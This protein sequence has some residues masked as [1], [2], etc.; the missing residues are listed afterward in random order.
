MNDQKVINILKFRNL[1][2]ENSR[3]LLK[4]VAGAFIIK[5][6]ALVVSLF[7]MPLYI[8][9]FGDQAI[10]GVWYTVLSVITWILNFDLGI[11]NGLRNQLVVSIAQKNNE[12]SRE[13]V[14]SAYILFGVLVLL[15]AVVGYSVSTVLNWN[16]VFNISEDLVSPRALSMVVKCVFTGIILQLYLNTISSIIYALQKS[17][18]NNLIS[19]VI[20]VSQLLFVL[21]A[22]ASTP[23]ENLIVLSKAYIFL[24][25]IPYLIG[26]IVVFNTSLKNARPNLLYFRRKNVKQ[27][28]GTGGLFFSCQVLYMVIIGTNEFFITYYTLPENTVEYSIY[29]KLFMLSGTFVALALSPVWSMVTK[30]IAER[31][32]DWLNRLYKKAKLMSLIAA[33]ANMSMIA[34]LQIIINIW[35][36][37]AAIK[38]NY[39]YAII[40]AIWGSVFIYQSVLSTFVCG[41]GRMGLQA[42]CYGIGVLLKVAFLVIAFN[43]TNA[44]IIV[45]ISNI[46]IFLP[47]C[48]I[49]DRSLNKFLNISRR[50][51]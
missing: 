30:A 49:Q 19:L 27:L 25:S 3:I 28:L 32:G 9:Y 46:I 7:T 2:N 21:F 29:N 51:I 20:S 16:T 44:W 33:F 10:L 8:S 43:Y 24:T 31:Q 34:V 26:S 13:L 4:N 5:G 48:I 18:I 50:D 42:K 47:Y 37:N 36:G 1:E 38:V 6:G 40:F 23:Q 14:S 22:R 12:K 35:L 11:G 41:T 45:M 15:F 17:V 39:G